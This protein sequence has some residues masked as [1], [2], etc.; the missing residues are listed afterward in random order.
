[1]DLDFTTMT[2]RSSWR[3][4]G[5]AVAFVAGALALTACGESTIQYGGGESGGSGADAPNRYNSLPPLDLEPGEALPGIHLR[6]GIELHRLTAEETLD[7]RVNWDEMTVELFGSA[8]VKF[9]QAEEVWSGDIISSDEFIFRIDN[10]TAVDDRLVIDVYEFE[11]L[12]VIHGEWNYTIHSEFDGSYAIDDNHAGVRRQNLE[13]IE[14]DPEHGAEVRL[15]DLLAAEING[16]LTGSQTTEV[17]GSLKFP[18]SW[19]YTFEGRIPLTGSTHPCATTIETRTRIRLTWSGFQREEYQAD[20]TPQDFCVDLLV[21]KGVLAVDTTFGMTSNITGTIGLDIGIP[22]SFPAIP[23]PLGPT[24]LALYFEPFVEGGIEVQLT[25]ESLLT[26]DGS[27]SFELPRGFEYIRL[28]GGYH[29]IPNERHPFSLDA[30]LSASI[31]VP[32]LEGKGKIF[33]KGGFKVHLATVLEN[34]GKLAGRIPFV[35]ISELSA[36]LTG[37]ELGLEVGIDSKYST[38]EINNEDTTCI[39]AHFYTKLY[40]K[41]QLSGEVKLSKRWKWKS[42]FT[43][44]AEASV[45][46]IWASYYNPSNQGGLAP[47]ERNL[48]CDD[49]PLA[50]QGLEVTLSWSEETDLDLY[51]RTPNGSVIYYLDRNA[52]GG[53]FLG[54]NCIGGACE[55]DLNETIVWEHQAVA[56][57]GEYAVWV[58]NHDGLEAASYTITVQSDKG[59]IDSFSGNVDGSAGA[60]SEEHTFTVG[61]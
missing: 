51:L 27:S 55:G 40:G 26:L 20:V 8:R 14:S 59:H 23:L 13:T 1:M 50:G 28:G 21:I 56:P 52:D 30:D 43:S 3:A 46:K 45:E 29:P 17:R 9:E 12:E 41:A 6:P 44:S 39:E 34:A 18:V 48:G 54:D 4:T 2:L 10:V 53:A 24:G 38:E 11:L 16:K 61:N 36:R 35:D 32:E 7:T 22:S 5:L 33:A 57:S 58:V 49:E 37:P 47:R 60:R 25:G 42:D 19:Q 31:T 15:A